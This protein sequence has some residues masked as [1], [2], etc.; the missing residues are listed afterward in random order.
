ME[1]SKF[2]KIFIVVY[3]V[4]KKHTRLEFPTDLFTQ[5]QF[6]YQNAVSISKKKISFV[7]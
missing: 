4:H 3:F 1:N 7:T 6:I 2:Q 5:M